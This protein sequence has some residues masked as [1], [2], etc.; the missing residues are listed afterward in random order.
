MAAQDLHRRSGRSEFASKLYSD[1]VGE[2][3]DFRSVLSSLLLAV[4]FPLL[5]PFFKSFFL[6]FDLLLLFR[7]ERL[8]TVIAATAS[9]S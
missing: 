6:F 2:S 7:R 5:M 8:T 3:L 4:C 9:Q 1:F